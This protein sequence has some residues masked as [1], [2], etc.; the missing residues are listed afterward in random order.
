MDETKPLIGEL[1][2]NAAAITLALADLQAIG[3]DA[4]PSV[5]GR[6]YAAGL[7][8]GQPMAEIERCLANADAAIREA[9][10]VLLRLLRP[11]VA[12]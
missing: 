7:A 2:M 8:H 6:L 10:S 3:Q 1:A 11:A 9:E 12:A 4:M 5:L